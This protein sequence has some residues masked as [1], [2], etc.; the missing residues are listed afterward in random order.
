MAL[1]SDGFC[2]VCSVLLARLI[3]KL[4]AHVSAIEV[5]WQLSHVDVSPCRIHSG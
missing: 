3:A 4:T 2:A 5:R 1:R